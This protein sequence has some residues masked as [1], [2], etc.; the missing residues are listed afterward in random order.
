MYYL[1]GFILAFALSAF[2]YLY[3]RKAPFLFLLRFLTYSIL[4]LLLLNPKIEKKQKIVHRPELYILADNSSSIKK[5]QAGKQVDKLIANIKKSNLSKKYNLHFFQFSD[6]LKTLDSLTYSE[7]KTAIGQVIDELKL[8]HQKERKAPV[9]LISDGQ[10]NSGNDYLFSVS[11]KPFQI[12]PVVTGDTTYHNDIKI[13]LLNVNPYVFK[14][15]QFSLEIFVSGNLKKEIQT[16]LK[17]IE[18]KSIIASKKI[19]LSPDKPA[20]KT[21]FLL[22]GKTKG[23]HQYTA[24]LTPVKNE[25]NTLNNR[26][27]FSVEVIENKQKIILISDIIHPDIGALKRSLKTNP[28]IDFVIKKP[29]ANIRFSDYNT[30]VLYQPTSNFNTVV[31]KILKLNKPWLI[32][33]GTHTDWNFINQKKLFFR[34]D[35]SGSNEV[36]FPYQNKKFSLFKLPGINWDDFPPLRD[37]Y[38]K[39]YLQTT[40]ETAL[41]SKVQGIATNEALFAFQSEKKQAVL[42]GENL[43]QWFI[44]A[45]I[46]E[47]KKALQELWLQTFRYLNLNQNFDRLQVNYRHQ[48]FQGNTI[49]ISARFLNENLE[50]DDKARPIIILKKS[51]GKQ[52]IPMLSSGDFYEVN[53][54]NL[55]PG[56]YSFSIQNQDKSLRKN[57]AFRVLSYGLEDKNLQ[58]DVKKLSALAQKTNGKIITP[59]QIDELINEL[60]KTKKFPASVNYQIQQN[61]LIDI[62]WLLFLLV[63][64]LSL[65]W[66][67]KKLRGEL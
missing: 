18:N 13:D 67:V 14:G 12:Y 40:S 66:F 33:T 2:Q 39:I 25:K 53:L 56:N 7:S 36:F 38:G 23:L 37:K 57:G 8:W 31:D 16:Q 20:V 41:L 49:K 4:I 28:Y 44:Q 65:E 6:H 5:Q 21:D 27:I 47:Q 26:K 42:F 46:K 11:N 48:Y 22:D 10:N 58:A 61:G 17:I 51:N 1:T 50:P 3:K 35:F 55:P 29:S 9:I 15:N 32:I 45:G 24:Y 34:K 62:K 19:R 52:Q 63:L 30:F 59:A 64:L 60:I 43:W 54:S